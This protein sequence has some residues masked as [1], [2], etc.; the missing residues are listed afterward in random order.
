MI[1]GACFG[2]H[3]CLCREFKEFCLKVNVLDYYSERT[4]KAIV[5]DP[6]FKLTHQFNE[7]MYDNIRR[8]IYSYIPKYASAYSTCSLEPYQ[9]GELYIGISDF[10]EITGIPLYDATLESSTVEAYVI[11]ALRTYTRGVNTSK[12]IYTDKVVVSVEQ[13][14]IDMS[15]LYDNTKE[16]LEVAQIRQREYDNTYKKYLNDREEY[17]KQLASY[18]CKLSAVVNE[19][20]AE[21]EKYVKDNSGTNHIEIPE[22][23]G[24]INFSTLEERR[25]DT[26]HYLHYLLRFKDQAVSSL[27]KNKPRPPLVPRCL[28]ASFSLITH[29][30][31]L[32]ACFIGRNPGKM[33]YFVIKVIFSGNIDSDGY[34]Q[35]KHHHHPDTW[36]VRRRVYSPDCPYGPCLESIAIAP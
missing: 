36:E 1:L 9:K 22:V 7:M 4:V 11:D 28:N 30:S 33:R 21:F 15:Y 10:G 31:D 8:Y 18:T 24:A 26:T 14:D 25:D 3:E 35:Y 32:R 6:L 23:I 16:V 19:N 5:S 13:L 27:F 2:E 29:L 12:H 17:L 34:L 20:R